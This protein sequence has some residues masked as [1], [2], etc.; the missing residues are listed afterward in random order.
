MTERVHVW[1]KPL[2]G[3]QDKP[4]VLLKKRSSPRCDHIRPP[5]KLILNETWYSR[6][7]HHE[8]IEPWTQKKKRML[9]SRCFSQGNLQSSVSICGW[10]VSWSSWPFK[11]IPFLTNRCLTPTS[12]QL[13]VSL[14]SI[15]CYGRT[16]CSLRTAKYFAKLIC[17]PKVKA[18]N[19]LVYF[20]NII[21][22]M[23]YILQC[24]GYPQHVIK[25]SWKL[26]S[27]SMRQISS[28]V[29]SSCHTNSKSDKFTGQYM[30]SYH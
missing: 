3:F 5:L 16:S 18:H 8:L 27:L 9:L 21:S 12:L 22:S 15:V 26:I 1:G 7:N 6:F 13:P 11:S 2:C 30:N 19:M 25:I 23:R 17:T 20:A 14:G 4:A 28:T 29:S 10:P 24:N